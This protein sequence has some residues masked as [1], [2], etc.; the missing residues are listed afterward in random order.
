MAW[1]I[2]NSNY[3]DLNDPVGSVSTS[4]AV[5]PEYSDMGTSSQ[6]SVCWIPSIGKLSCLVIVILFDMVS[7]FLFI[8]YS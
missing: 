8:Y 4:S 2:G 5:N 3:V 6:P 1:M 7:L